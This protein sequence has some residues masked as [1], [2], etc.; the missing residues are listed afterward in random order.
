MKILFVCENYIP[1]YGGAEVVFKNLAENYVKLGYEVILLT[2]KLKGTKRKEIIDGV[3]VYRVNSFG[4]RYLFTFLSLFKAIKFAKKSDVI[5]T[6]SFNGAPP[7]WLAAK[8]TKKPVVITVHEIWIR[9]WNKV[10]SFPKWKCLI[11]ELLEKA[12]YS[13]NYD[14][15][16]C[17]SNATR[18][19][20]LQ[21]GIKPEKAVTI[22]N[23]LDYEFWNE[24]DIDNHKVKLIKKELGLENNFVYFSWGRPGESKGFEYVIKAVPEISKIIPN[25]ILVLTF[26]SIDKYQ[27]KY[28]QLMKLIKEL[29]IE[30]KVKLIDTVQHQDLRY[31][32]KAFDCAVIP[33]IAEGFGYNAVE[34]I[35]MGIPAVV[36][37]AGSLP[38]VVSG[39]HLMFESKNSLD[40]AKKVILV[41]QGK[42][43]NEEVREYNW[44]PSVEKYLEVY[45]K[46]VSN[47]YAKN[48]PS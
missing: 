15:Y 11:H 5:Q 9:K 20:L 32:L 2:Q 45:E 6:T 41:S 17:V 21:T 35:T 14:K 42:Y 38:E 13:F 37:D 18:K 44:E 36:S 26:G 47:D 25:A 24:K 27:K 40:L 19:D 22:H 12:I 34:A 28:D 8:L 4:S 16:I 43:N 48:L 1:H 23:G 39:K 7:A 31:Y 3:K 10:T 30:D 29:K 46:L 33:S